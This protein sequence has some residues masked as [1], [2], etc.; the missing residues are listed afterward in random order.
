[1]PGVQHYCHEPKNGV[2]GGLPGPE[3]V[4]S[5]GYWRVRM[6]TV[7]PHLTEPVRIPVEVYLDND[8]DAVESADFCERS[9]YRKTSRFVELPANGEW[10]GWVSGELSQTVRP[11]VWYFAVLDC[12]EQLKSTTRIKFEFIAHQ[13]NGSEFSAE[14]RGTRGI[15]WVQL[16]ISVLFTWFFAKECRKFVRSADSLHPVV[17]TLACA[18]ALQVVH[19]L[20]VGFGKIKDDASYKF[21]ENEVIRLLLAVWFLWAVNETRKEAGMKLRYFLAKFAGLGMVYFFS[22]PVLFVITGFFAPYYRQKV[23]L[24]GWFAIKYGVFAW[25]TSMFLTRGD[26]FQVSTLNSSFLP[27]GVR[28]GLDKEE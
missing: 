21:Y 5:T 3:T 22:Y 28:P 9:R 17:I 11:H 15:V 27:G 2:L 7:R 19:V 1:M 4:P 10:S 25:M 8:W 24:L 18:I 26:Y 20:L 12:G 13:E 23:M 16:I 6:R 14:L